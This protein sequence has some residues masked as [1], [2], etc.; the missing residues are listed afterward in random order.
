MSNLKITLIQ[1]NQYWEDKEK[2]LLQFS[3]L[4]REIEET[5]LIL[6]PEM[7]H[8]SFSM[9]TTLLSERMSES[10]A[11]TWLINKAKEKNCAF[12]TSFIVEENGKYFNRGV[13][14]F[15]EGN[16]QT[17]DKRKLFTLTNEDK[18][19]TAGKLQQIVSYKGWK[20][21]LQ[22]CFDLRFP[23]ISRNKS[24]QNVI[25]YDLCL[26]IANWPQKRSLHWKSLLQARAIENQCYLVGLN[27]VGEDGKGLLYSGDS[28]VF[29]P[30]GEKLIEDFPFE[31]KN[32]TLEI[33]KEKLNEIRTNLNFL[34][35]V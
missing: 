5:D 26:Y 2:N 6:L 15:P 25:D 8:T 13:F 29:N 33:N 17:Y 31:E 11:L 28:M 24:S 14:V 30:F 9:N 19:F 21:N 22:I 1:C 12:Y 35:D 27:R 10:T 34:Q 16:Y 20:I 7:F 32:I 18:F 4:I 3:N 23:E